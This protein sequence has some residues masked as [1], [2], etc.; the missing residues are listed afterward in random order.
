MNRQFNLNIT[1]N[2]HLPN[3]FALTTIQEIKLL[4]KQ[5]I[6]ASDSIRRKINQDRN[7]RIRRLKLLRQIT[8]TKN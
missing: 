2:I 7:I 6:A 3:C 4:D 5:M 8:W 1:N